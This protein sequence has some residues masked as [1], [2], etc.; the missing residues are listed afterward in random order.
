MGTHASTTERPQQSAACA[1]GTRL[2]RKPVHGSVFL[3]LFDS[4]PLPRAAWSEL[5]PVDL[6]SAGRA[7]RIT[8]KFLARCRDI[9][10]GLDDMAELLV[11]ELVANAC[12]AMAIEPTA[13]NAKVELSLRLFDGHLLIEVADSS[14]QVPQPKLEPDTDALDRRGL[15]VVHQLSDDWGW[16]LRPQGRKVVFC[17]L[18]CTTD[19][20]GRETEDGQPPDPPAAENRDASAI[21]VPT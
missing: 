15:A 5:L 18:P 4:Q 11:S 7:R 17:I 21:P 3:R 8:R 6:Q 1:S 20:P 16:F 12:K 2:H 14:P 19:K 10:D 13:G 9:P